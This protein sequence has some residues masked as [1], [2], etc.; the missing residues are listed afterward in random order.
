MEATERG[1]ESTIEDNEIFDLTG[2]FETHSAKH[3]LNNHQKQLSE[4]LPSK[5][6]VSVGQIDTNSGNAEITCAVCGEKTTYK[7]FDKHK[8]TKIHRSKYATFRKKRK[9]TPTEEKETGP[10]TTVAKSLSF[11]MEPQTQSLH[12]KRKVKE[13]YHVRGGNPLPEQHHLY[14]VTLSTYFALKYCLSKDNRDFR[15]SVINSDWNEFGDV[16]IEF[17]TYNSVDEIQAIQCKQVQTRSNILV[18]TLAAEMGKFSIKSRCDILMQLKNK[19][20]KSYDKA[21]FKLFT[22]SSLQVNKD[23]VSKFVYNDDALRDWKNAEDKEKWKD[24]E[25]KIPEYKRMHL[26]N[27]TDDSDDICIFKVVDKDNKQ[28]FDDLNKFSMFTN[29]RKLEGLKRSIKLM[30]QNKFDNCGDVSQE[31]INYVCTHFKQKQTCKKL[32][33][34]SFLLKIAELLLKPFLVSSE[35]IAETR[36]TAWNE[37]LMIFDLIIIRDQR[38]VAENIYKCFN[39]ILRRETNFVENNGKLKIEKA[40]ISELGLSEVIFEKYEE[41]IELTLAQAY[42]AMWKA[43]FI[44]LVLFVNDENELK[45]ISNI[46]T[47]LHEEH[48]TLKFII[49]T[50][51]KIGATTFY[52]NLKIF[53]NLKDLQGKE[54][55][56]IFDS[57]QNRIKIKVCDTSVLL[58]EIIDYNPTFLEKISPDVLLNM[59]LEKYSFKYVDMS[60][61]H[62][63]IVDDPLVLSKE[64]V[65]LI[66]N[67]PSDDD[68]ENQ[69]ENLSYVVNVKGNPIYLDVPPVL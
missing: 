32:S 33:R 53:L 48:I 5:S 61:D 65:D 3:T 49:I 9:I 52:E 1:Q 34:N 24:N 18:P 50:D 16:V 38:G 66:H 35:N 60:M 39:Y 10:S 56:T 22:V 17:Y 14:I 68:G 58:K 62:D 31:L 42:L 27:T 40:N 20:K 11:Q 69:V 46:I 59:L 45:T 8:N 25:L 47:F 55:K 37:I 19:K 15:I 28:V 12:D 44:P 26:L 51:L 29:Q 54:T 36:L 41:T 4:A 43:K 23:D 2:L 67:S 64:K 30:L 21:Y 6:K 57:I 7:E 63:V 13:T